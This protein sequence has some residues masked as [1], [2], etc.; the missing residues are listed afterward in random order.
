M[1]T[2]AVE[3]PV[4]IASSEQEDALLRACNIAAAP[5]RCELASRTSE[6]P[7]TFAVVT[8][9]GELAVQVEVGRPGATDWLER[10]L[11][12]APEDP[13]IERWQAVGFTIGT[14]FGASSGRAEP[15]ALPAPPPA[16]EKPPGGGTTPDARP[17]TPA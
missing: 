13:P 12:F 16:E 17:L 1:A 11:T 2:I 10:R 4:A 7:T 6:A 9:Q 14:L 8:W 5:D 3:M 15:A